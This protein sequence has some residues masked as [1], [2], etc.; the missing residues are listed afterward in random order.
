MKRAALAI[1]KAL[2]L[3]LATAF[4]QFVTT[5]CLGQLDSITTAFKAAAGMGFSG[6][7]LV[8]EDGRIRFNHATGY[9]RFED[10][11][12]LKKSDIFEL[13]SVSKQFTA[14]IVMMLNEKGML[15]YDDLVE[16]YLDIPYKGITIRHLL[17]HTSGLPDYLAVMVAHWDKTKVAGNADAIEYL[18]R[19]APP[20][21]F[22]PGEKY[23][24]SNTGYLLLASIAE[25]VTGRDFVDLCRDWIF[26]PLKM[27]STDIRPLQKKA[28]TE[29]FAAGH[30]KDSTG[31]YVNANRFQEFDYTVWLGNRKG[32]GRISSTAK[33]L[34]KWDRA[35]YTGKLVQPATLEQA[36][37]PMKLNNGTVSN[38]GFG[39]EIRSDSALGKM[40]LHNGDNPGYSTEI[41]RCIE[42]H[43]T[44]ILLCNNAHP[45]FKPLISSTMKALPLLK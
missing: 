31:K 23:S 33:D 35:L 40:V 18:N 5:Q 28:T 9:R 45:A 36:F 10:E 12:K 22:A 19:Y 30:L 11:K 44:I 15:S 25:K 24:Y 16:K 3:L 43:Y 14:M 37:F 34:L 29:N 21:L 26:K 42:K 1:N 38:Y 4:L 32:P 41:I 7:L 20:A 8:A 13:A 2:A 17:T 39:W 27:K 6:V